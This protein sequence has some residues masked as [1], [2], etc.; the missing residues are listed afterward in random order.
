[1]QHSQQLWNLT[2]RHFLGGSTAGLGAAALGQLLAADSWA[3]GSNQAAKIV[4]PLAAKQPPLPAKA[5]SV[6]YLHM[7]GSPPQ[8]ELFDYKPKL[9]EYN[10]KDCPDEYLKGERFAFIKGHPQLLGT[11]YKFSRH[12]ESGQEISELLPLLSSLADDLCIVRSMHSDQFNHAPAQML[13]YTGSPQFGKPS[14]G[15][16][17][18]Y[19]LGSENQDLPGFVVLVSGNKV[20][21]AGKSVWGSG[22]LP[23]VFQG[24]QCRT[25]GEPVLFV[26]NPAGMNRQVRR[27]SLDTLRELNQLQMA[28]QGDPEIATRIAQ[29][30]MAYRMQI[31]VPEVMDIGKESAETHEFYGSEPGETSFANNCLLARRLVESG[32]RF[33][34]LFDWGWD[35]HGTGASND[36]VEHLPKKCKEID[37]PIYALLTDL[38]RRGLLDETLVVWS[39]EFG[40]TPMNEKRDNSKYLGRD[41]HPHSMSLWMAGGGIKPGFSY[42]ATDELG[43]HVTDKKMH[44]HDLQ[45]TILHQ[46]GFDPHKFSVPYQGL[47]QRLIGPAEE[48]RVV[49]DLIA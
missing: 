21:S 6:I 22:F 41:H 14:M 9:Q 49:T 29:Y 1:M 37:T 17:I 44:I 38:K 18:T 27:L 13:L 39:G 33:V 34:Q 48:P 7:A 16:W 12:G 45:A 23:G 8:Q 30:E 11:P 2:R 43:Y 25:K 47:N 31:S 32:V 46:L 3:A 10:D 15:S 40:R 19:G 24:V 26:N 5:K 42:G 28:Q 35:I 20:P 36:I 4:Q